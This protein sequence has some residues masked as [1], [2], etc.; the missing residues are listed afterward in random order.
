MITR[1][2]S[3]SC[4]QL[5]ILCEGEPV[6]VSVCHCLECKRRTGSAFSW[7]AR[8]PEGRVRIEGRSKVFERVGDEGSRLRFHFCPDCGSTVHYENSDAPG[9]VAVPVGGFA[10]PDFPEPTVSV[11]DPMRRCAWVSLTGDNLERLG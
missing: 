5:Q 4:G 3:C 10:D 11:Y 1:C 6:R 9:F 2:A 8:Y 7:N